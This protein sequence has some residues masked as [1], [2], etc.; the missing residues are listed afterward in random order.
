MHTQSDNGQFQP[1]ISD[2]NAPLR[3]KNLKKR[4]GTVEA[5]KEFP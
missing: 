3:V 5:L 4:F 2:I 1:L